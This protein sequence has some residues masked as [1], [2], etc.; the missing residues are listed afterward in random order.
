MEINEALFGGC[1]CSLF[2]VLLQSFS[3]IDTHWKI[4]SS[5]F[6]AA[7]Q[8]LLPNAK[9]NPLCFSI[10]EHLQYCTTCRCD[11]CVIS[12][13]KETSCTVFRYCSN[14]NTSHTMWPLYILK[15]VTSCYPPSKV[16]VKYV[17]VTNEGLSLMVLVELNVMGPS[18]SSDI[19]PSSV[20]AFF[21]G[22][23]HCEA[24]TFLFYYLPSAYSPKA[25]LYL[26]LF[27][28]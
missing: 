23:I 14:D 6:I 16:T 8:T 25:R 12:N 24:S 20:R 9:Q 3:E 1:D 28:M 26:V 7:R 4:N 22:G 5:S 27:M 18:L 13:Q 15:Q 11:N 17:R 10:D 21:F 2:V 19:V